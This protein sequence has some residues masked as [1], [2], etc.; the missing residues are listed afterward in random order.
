MMKLSDPKHR[1]VLACLLIYLAAVLILTLLTHNY[2]TY[3]RSV[4]LTLSKS[5]RLMLRSGDSLLI[6]KNVAG[7][8]ALFLPLGLLLPALLRGR[9]R[10]L[11]TV[12][13]GFLFSL[14]IELVQYF[15]ASRIFDIDDLL[16]N[17]LGALTGAVVFS[18]TVFF[19]HRIFFFS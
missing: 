11:K 18:M 14:A 15:I 12:A 19:R 16:L 4:N 3:G 1:L 10:F 8:V 6:L 5:I 9:F 13:S 7:N 2:Y 17:T